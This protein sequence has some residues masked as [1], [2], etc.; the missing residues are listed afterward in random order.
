MPATPPIDT[1]VE[2]TPVTE[3]MRVRRFALPAFALLVLALAAAL[4]G[5]GLGEYR[6]KRAVASKQLQV[7]VVNVG[8]GEAAWVRTPGGRFVLLGGGPPEAGRAVVESLRR[9]GAER[10]DLLLLPYPYAE[11]LGGIPAILRAF[12]VDKVL[13][14]GGPAINQLHDEVRRQLAAKQTP[15]LR[16]RAGDQQR[17]DGVAID[18]LAPTDPAIEVSPAA[19]NNSLVVRIG[20][21]QTGFLFAGGTE[22]AGEDALIA[23]GSPLLA[24]DWLRISRFGTREASSPELLRLVS[25]DFVVLSVGAQN[26]GGYPHAETLQRLSASGAAVYRTDQALRTEISFTSDG[27]AVVAVPG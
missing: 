3:R 27:A 2:T 9:A 24:S 19:A 20:W 11:S 22:R 10:I 13:E 14:P 18:I 23:R 21:G 26:S 7:T 17:L 5:F 8:H 1:D 25:P 6:G 4:L 12:P 15:V 16:V